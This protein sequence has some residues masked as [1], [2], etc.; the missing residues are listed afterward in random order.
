MFKLP[1]ISYPLAID[2]IGKSLAMGEEHEIHCLN[3]GCHHTARLNMV[4]LGHRIGFEHS[5]LVQDIGR[6]FYCPRC[7][8]AG[9]P[10]KRIGLTC[11]PLTAQ[12][13]EWPRERQLLRE[14]SIRAR[15]E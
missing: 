14:K 1:E 6:F 2:T 15:P 9:R 12:H 3:N 5:C 13:S 8:E 7:R 4:A 11:H 10:D